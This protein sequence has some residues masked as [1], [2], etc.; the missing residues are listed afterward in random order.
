MLATSF[1][2]LTPAQIEDIFSRDDP[3]ALAAQQHLAAAAESAYYSWQPRPTRVEKFDEQ[4]AFVE[5]TASKFAILLGGTGSGKTIAAAHKTARYVLERIPPRERCPFW[6]IGEYMDQICDVAWKEKLSTIIPQHAIHKFAWH[7]RNREWPAA[8]L[9]K[10]P[11]HP[12]KVGW[13]LEFKSYAQGIGSMKAR[14]IGGYW[15]NEEVPFSLVAEVQGRCRDYD[16]PG[17]ADF[18]PVEAKSPEWI[19]AYESPPAGWKFFHLNTSLNSALPKEWFPRW[20]ST[21]PED[22]R[23]MRTI[24]KFAILS[25]AVYKE[26]RKSAHVIGY[27]DFYGM[28]GYRDI[29]R[30]W[31]RFRGIDFGFNNPFC[32]LW[33]AKSPDSDYFVYRE[34][35]HSQRLNQ[36]H[37]EQIHEAEEWTDDCWHGPTYSDHDPQQR[38]ELA[39]LGIHCTPANKSINQGIETV[40]KLMLPAASGRPRLFVFSHC[41]NLI[42]EIGGYQ[43]P[44]GTD[45][46]SPQDVPLDVDN[47]S[48]DALRYIL[49]TE[50][51]GLEQKTLGATLKVTV[52]GS[53]HGVAFNRVD[54]RRN[55][56]TAEVRKRG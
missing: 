18:T 8:V 17:W 31:R 50:R 15:F 41:E 24:G 19:E 2:G 30:H 39:K 29:P 11:L 5:D 22:Q 49:H 46:R 10:H 16:S 53:R 56:L 4:Q 42:R 52:D 44:K 38:A 32:C 33:V 37:A 9:L 43:W 27:D 13:V 40:R 28:T 47:H 1:Y 3:V 6:I 7:D 54:G 26:F 25:G 12:G 45:K 36:W 20:I 51:T 34:H 48:L 23:E 14:S 21:I 55:G 35:F